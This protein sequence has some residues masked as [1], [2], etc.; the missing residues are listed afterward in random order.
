VAQLNDSSHLATDNGDGNQ[1]TGALVPR[2]HDLNGYTAIGTPM[3]APVWQDQTASG[4]SITKMLHSFRRRWMLA[5]FIGLLLGIPA[6]LATWLIFP[7]QYE[8][9]A[10]LRFRNLERLQDDAGYLPGEREKQW[11]ERQLYLIR[12]QM[13]LTRTLGER[14]VANLSLIRAESE[15]ISFLLDSITVFSPKDSDLVFIRMVGERADEMVE[16]VR[17]LTAKYIEHATN[18]TGTDRNRNITRL[19]NELK[20]NSDD[21]RAKNA[22]KAS[23]AAKS[24]SMDSNEANNKRQRIQGEIYDLREQ[25]KKLDDRLWHAQN[26][27]DELKAHHE[28]LDEGKYPEA[29]LMKKIRNDPQLYELQQDI[30]DA[31]EY[32]DAAQASAKYANAPQVLRAQA[33]L[34]SLLEEEDQLKS[35]LLEGAKMELRYGPEGGAQSLRLAESQVEKLNADKL[36]LDDEMKA[37]QI[38]LD[39]LSKDN[40]DLV[41]L[42]S[43]IKGI[44]DS[45]TKLRAQLDKSYLE[46]TLPPPVDVIEE[47]EMPEGSTLMYRVILTSFLGILCFCVGVGGVVLLEY[48]KQR[49]STLNDIGYGGLGIRVLGTVPNLARLSRQASSKNGEA[50]GAVSGIL[51]ESIDSVRTMLLSNKRADAPKVILVTSAD[52][53]EGKTTVASHLAAS[54]ARAGRRTLLV[55]GDLRKPAIHMLFDMPLSAGVCEVLRGEAEIDAV[56]HPAQVEGMWVMLA[57]HCDQQAIASLAK[58]SAAALFRTLRADYEFV[59]IDSG[60]ALAFADTMLMGSHADAAVMAILRDVSQIPKVYEAR[61][62]LEAI[63][64]QVLGGVVGGV[65]TNGSRSYALLN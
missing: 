36:S 15:P 48:T 62:R 4:M 55:D 53:H 38:E 21:L 58:E 46:L 12:S 37:K 29:L 59:V 52:E 65:A 5:L 35:E 18:E 56:V 16:I 23:L 17:T 64:M 61:E 44:N 2:D 28:A 1:V 9:Q 50:A 24:G 33:R 41:M 27:V 60:P 6:A 31:K 19:E 22:A 40:V 7:K 3:L 25:L 42:E 45:T 30:R 43:E 14:K 13:L 8:V 39:E 10:M 34:K 32:R 54:L 49:V 26:E 51:A 63:G 57:G 47:A 11:R 20:K